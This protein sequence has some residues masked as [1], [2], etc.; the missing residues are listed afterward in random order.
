MKSYQFFPHHKRNAIWSYHFFPTPQ[1]NCYENCVNYFHTWQKKQSLNSYPTTLTFE[2]KM[3]EFSPFWNPNPNHL[4][5]Q[6]AKNFWI[7]ENSFNQL[8]L[9][10]NCLLTL[11]SIRNPKPKS[12]RNPIPHSNT[13]LTLNPARTLTLNPAWTLT[14]TFTVGCDCVSIGHKKSNLLLPR[15]T[16][17]YL[18]RLVRAILFS[19]SCNGNRSSGSR[20]QEV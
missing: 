13:T 4:G 7:L 1:K 6:N 20:G 5:F 3:T 10:F 11:N 16:S 12:S 8:V 17:K 15:T 14:L 18:L 9:A 2:S 19:A